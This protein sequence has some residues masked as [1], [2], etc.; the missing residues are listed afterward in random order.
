MRDYTHWSYAL[1]LAGASRSSRILDVGC[2]TGKMLRLLERNGFRKLTGIDPYTSSSKG[3]V[4]I[5]N[6]T[7]DSYEGGPFD[8]VMIND[9]LEH[10]PNPLATLIQARNLLDG[11]MIVRIP[12]IGYAWRTYGTN[13][14]ALDP[15]RHQHVLSARGM[16]ILA[17]RAGLLSRPAATTRLRFSSGRASNTSGTFH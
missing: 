6:G 8:V 15:P 9:S 3:S 16:R 13:W 12:L 2:G 14:V 7:L 10:V 17:G 4:T 11:K 1:R 5:I